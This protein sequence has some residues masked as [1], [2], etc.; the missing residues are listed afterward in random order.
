MEWEKAIKEKKGVVVRVAY[1]NSWVL[2]LIHFIFC[3]VFLQGVK[4][5]YVEIKFH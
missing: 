1:T 5:M 2:F 4:C 3:E